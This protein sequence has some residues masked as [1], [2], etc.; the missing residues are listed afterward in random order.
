MVIMHAG[1]I[2]VPG[3]AIDWMVWLCLLTVIVSGVEYVWIWSR[4]ARLHGW[5]RRDIG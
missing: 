1:P 3:E 2:P 5:K 4:K